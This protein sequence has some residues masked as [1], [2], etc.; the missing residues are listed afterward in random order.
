M[1]LQVLQARV[2]VPVGLPSS[3]T[4][5]ASVMIRPD[6]LAANARGAMLTV[7]SGFMPAIFIWRSQT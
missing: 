5:E 7:Y 1:S 4:I 6:L 3:L 2:A